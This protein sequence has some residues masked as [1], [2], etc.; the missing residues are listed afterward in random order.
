MAGKQSA[1]RKHTISTD[2]LATTTPEM[3]VGK[4]NVLSRR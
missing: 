3:Q 2:K 4:T 1:A